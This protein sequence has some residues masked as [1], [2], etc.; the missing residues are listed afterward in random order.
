MRPRYDVRPGGAEVGCH[1][2]SERSPWKESPILKP[3]RRGGGW[4]P[5]AKRAQPME[6]VANIET[7]PE[8]RRLVATGGATP[9]A[10]RNPWKESPILRPPRRGGGMLP[11]VERTRRVSATRGNRAHSIARPG[12]AEV[13]CHG[14]SEQSERNPWKVAPK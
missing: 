2:R 5:R 1:G 3:P 12:G 8:G 6:R 9:K 14:W 10:E 4:L 13:G 7:A 11:R